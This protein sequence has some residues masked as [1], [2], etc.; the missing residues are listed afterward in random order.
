[1]TT[2]AFS[3]KHGIM[4][5]DRMSCESNTKYGRMTKIFRSRDHLV[6]FSGE[7]GV[8]MVLLRWFER[9]A[10][11]EEWPDPH[12]EDGLDANML[13]V[14]PGGRIMAYE[15]FPIPMTLESEFSAIGSG[16]DFALAVMQLGY[17]PVKAIEVA[18]ELD[19]FTGG[20]VDVLHLK[21][22]VH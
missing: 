20:G 10:L 21:D 2:V 15:R 1:M 3:K 18:S 12:G 17:D 22:P 19:C 14:T 4:A 6:G 11:E 7:S 9:G 16:R 5:G 8:A 13:V